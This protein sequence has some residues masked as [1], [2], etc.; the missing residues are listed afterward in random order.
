MIEK[1][2]QWVGI[3]F[4]LASIICLFWEAFSSFKRRSNLKLTTVGT[5][6]LTVSVIGYFV[7]NIILSK[8][9]V[10]YVFPIL[11]IACLWGYIIC[12]VI[13]ACIISKQNRKNKK[14]QNQTADSEPQLD[15]PNADETD[16][17]AE[18]TN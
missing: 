4:A 9:K 6:F 11:W 13:S 18:N 8:T 12:N 2:L 3:I 5:V 17:V 7:T 16:D 15:N 1:I 10:P 14:L